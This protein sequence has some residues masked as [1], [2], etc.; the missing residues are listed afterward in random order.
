MNNI[1]KVSVIIPTYNRFAYLLNTIESI[2]KQNYK[3]LEIIVINDGSSQKEYYNHNWNDITIIHAN[4]TSREKFGKPSPGYIRNIGI[5][6]A[7]GEYI[8]FCDDDDIWLP[9]KL[10][11]QIKH[12]KETGCNISS[13]DGYLGYGI[14]DHSKK[15]KLYNKEF[16]Y[17]KIKKIFNKSGLS[18]IDN[19]YP[20]I[21]KYNMIKIHNC[22]ITSSVVMHRSLLLKVGMMGFDQRK[23]D[24]KY[25]LKCL[26]HTD[27]VYIDYPYFYYDNDHGDGKNH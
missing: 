8:A 9:G 21:W 10:E 17:N 23:Q 20:K 25:W 7:I 11:H 18:I 4:P 1:D 24:Y 3:N 26:L 19:G 22:I 27:L 12:M 16:W 6:K 15:Y 2:K 13:T 14:Y 5:N